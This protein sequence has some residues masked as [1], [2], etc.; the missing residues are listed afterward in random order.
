MDVIIIA[1]RYVIIVN[2][3]GVA[4]YPCLCCAAARQTGLFSNISPLCG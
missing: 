4:W 1:Y 2:P 3:V